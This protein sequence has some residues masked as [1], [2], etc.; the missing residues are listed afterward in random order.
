MAT[1]QRSK[2][3]RKG[4]DPGIRKRKETKKFH[5]KTK[6]KKVRKKNVRKNIKRRKKISS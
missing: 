2:N 5:Q 6:N 1:H 4:R 3:Q